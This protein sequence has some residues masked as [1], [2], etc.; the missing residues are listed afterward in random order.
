MSEAKKDKPKKVLFSNFFTKLKAIKHIEVFISIIFIVIILLIY[1]S[2]DS[3]QSNKTKEENTTTLSSTLEYSA[4][5]EKR[6]EAVL[7]KIKGAGDVSVMVNCET[8]YELKI[9]YTT[10]T[11][12]KT[13]DSV[14]SETVTQTPVLITNNGETNPIVLEQIS[15][16]IKNII[17]IARGAED[18][19]VK[20]EL[21]KAV[22]SLLGIPSSSIEVFTGN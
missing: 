6:V 15:P 11:V 14:L 4:E 18:T 7:S 12:K 10:E 3:V 5:I 2:T 1:F 19:N 17:I 16:K 13:E 20:L 22:E 9:A 21:I 8:G